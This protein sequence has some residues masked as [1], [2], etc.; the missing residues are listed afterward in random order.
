[1]HP[2]RVA[3]YGN[4]GER[5]NSALKG[6]FA[7]FDQ[8]EFCDMKSDDLKKYSIINYVQ[9]V[10]LREKIFQTWSERQKNGGDLEVE[11]LIQIIKSWFESRNLATQNQTLT[12]ETYKVSSV[13][14]GDTGMADKC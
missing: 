7:Q 8:C 9:Q 10:K 1:M 3:L 13:I 12:K 11:E 6:L 5:I 14:A 2:Q 4:Q